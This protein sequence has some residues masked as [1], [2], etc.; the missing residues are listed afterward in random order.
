MFSLIAKSSQPYKYS[1]NGL[2]I[3]PRI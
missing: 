3:N 2:F 1:K